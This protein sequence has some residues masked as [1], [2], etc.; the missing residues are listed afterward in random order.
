MVFW[1][2]PIPLF[3]FSQAARAPSA[4]LRSWAFS[5]F[6]L[7][8][9]SA[10]PASF[11][12]AMRHFSDWGGYTAGLL[13]QHGFG[14][15]LSG[16]VMAQVRFAAILGFAP[17]S[18]CCADRPHQA[19][20]DPRHL[21]H[22]LWKTANKMRWLT[23]GADGL[24]GVAVSP[25]LGV[26][27]FDLYG[28]TAYVYSMVVLFLAFLLVRRIIHS[29]FGLA[30]RG[31]KENERRM[32]ALGTPVARRSVV[33]YTIGAA[34]AGLAGALLTQIYLVCLTRRAFVR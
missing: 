34:P 4:G 24:Q 22:A 14:E 6:L 29:P 30:L 19:H 21:P 31:I 28:H 1:V 2:L 16:L 7:I 20:G 17:A 32:N 15:P 3:S 23:G 13:A 11:P 9:F 27:N 10:T 26:W 5:P 12:S 8:L 25:I 18:S 33:A